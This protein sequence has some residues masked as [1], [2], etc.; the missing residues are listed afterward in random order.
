MSNEEVVDNILGLLNQHGAVMEI[1]LG[2][3]IKVDDVVSKIQEII[4]TA[5]LCSTRRVGWAHVSRNKSKN[6]AKSHLVP[7]HLV[8][9]L[10]RGDVAKIGV[11]P[12]VRGNLVSIGVLTLDDRGPGETSVINLTLAVVITS[13]EEGSLSIVL[14]KEIEQ[15]GCVTTWAIIVSECDGTGLVTT[16]NAGATVSNVAENRSRQC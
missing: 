16:V 11:R 12:G 10:E 1:I 9:A 3:Q 4:L 14:G 13:D 7:D 2:I 6:I 15:V 5:A 8:L